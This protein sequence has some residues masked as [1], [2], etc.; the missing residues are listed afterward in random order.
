MS[1]RTSSGFFAK[2]ALTRSL[3]LPFVVWGA[4]VLVRSIEPWPQ[5]NF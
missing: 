1:R 3:G 2:M 5:N 4:L